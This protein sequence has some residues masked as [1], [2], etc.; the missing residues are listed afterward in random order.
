MEQGELTSA[1]A[2]AL[3]AAP[4]GDEL[5]QLSYRFGQMAREVLAREESLRR[6]VEE[7]RV[8]INQAKRDR[9]VSAITETDY[10]QSLRS[11]ADQMRRAHA[12]AGRADESPPAPA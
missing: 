5:A 12:R 7:L 4:G 2:A 10:F 1:E 3:A 8:E 11:R 6:Q 9:E